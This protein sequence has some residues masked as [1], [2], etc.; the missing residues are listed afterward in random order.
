MSKRKKK[1]RVCAK[2][3]G[4]EGGMGVERGASEMRK[5]R[6][7]NRYGN[8]SSRPANSEQE[9][10]EVGPVIAECSTRGLAAGTQACCSHSHPGYPPSRVLHLAC[11]DREGGKKCGAIGHAY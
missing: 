8:E 11:S 4:R 9:R 1:R 2:E 6:Q 10:A 3:E 7:G 5:F